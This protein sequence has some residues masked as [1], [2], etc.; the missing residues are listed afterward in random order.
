MVV[1]FFRWVS[2]ASADVSYHVFEAPQH[3]CCDDAQEESNDVEDGGGP[4]QVVEVH[5]VLTAPHLR[6]LMVAPHQLHT[7][8][9]VG[10][11]RTR[12]RK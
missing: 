9:P 6:V 5:H 4:Q 10:E 8:G 11:T 1:F 12:E 7:A 2:Q 3:S